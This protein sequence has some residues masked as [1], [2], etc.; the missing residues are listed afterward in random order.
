[1]LTRSQPN[2]DPNWICDV[3]NCL[4]GI[5]EVNQAKY[6]QSWRCQEC[7]FDICIKC[8]LK[9]SEIDVEK[10]K[11]YEKEEDYLMLVQWVKDEEVF[12]FKSTTLA[13]FEEEFNDDKAY[14]RMVLQNQNVIKKNGDQEM[15]EITASDFGLL[16]K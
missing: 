10:L 5:K 14:A 16:G 1:M 8:C 11:K 7:D 3:E 15:L 13:L 12:V 2:R 9:Y 6:N 4:S